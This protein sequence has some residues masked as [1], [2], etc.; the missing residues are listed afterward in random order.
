MRLDRSGN[1]WVSTPGNYYDIPSRTFVIDTKTDKVTDTLE[2]PNANMA[3]RGD[4][5]ATVQRHLGHDH[6]KSAYSFTFIDD[7]TEN[8]TTG[9]RLLYNDGTEGK[10]N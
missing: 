1:L 7:P 4:F 3:L 8:E 6:R 9:G 5:A 10:V 2:V